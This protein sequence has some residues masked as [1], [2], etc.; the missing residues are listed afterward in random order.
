MA[1]FR[2]LAH[3]AGVVTVTAALLTAVFTSPASACSCVP[4]T[5]GE[6]YERATHVFSGVVRSETLEAGDPASPY[7]DKYRYAV[8]V[9]TEYKGDVPRRVDVVT[10]TSGGLCGIRLYPGVE[11][12][13][14]A[15]GD[16][17]D[18]R[19]E[20]HYCSGTR[21]ASAGPPVT[22]VPSTSTTTPPTSTCA[23]ATP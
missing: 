19:V 10:P 12:V 2:F 15:H 14:F 21:P 13:V 1:R 11:Y 22:T 8:A 4:S 7:D 3:A 20:S 6:R 23:T 17:A 5:E 9:R 18:G 16:S